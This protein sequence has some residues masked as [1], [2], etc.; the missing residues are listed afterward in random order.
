MG[1]S[2]FSSHYKGKSGQFPVMRELLLVIGKN[3]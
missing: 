2:S 1:N 3:N